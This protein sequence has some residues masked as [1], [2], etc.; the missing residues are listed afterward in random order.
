MPFPGRISS[1]VRAEMI[2]LFDEALKFRRN[3]RLE[4]IPSPEEIFGGRRHTF[5]KYGK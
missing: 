3:H 5:K 1:L 4:M 2:L